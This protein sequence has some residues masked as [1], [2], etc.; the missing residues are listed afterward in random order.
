[1]EIFSFRYFFSSFSK[2]L[3]YLPVTLLI[4]IVSLVFSLA[5]GL[6]FAWCKLQKNRVV[7][8]IV[9]FYVQIIRG[10]PFI[11]L[12]FII[13]FGLPK[14]F[15]SLF[16]LDING[17]TKSIYI[18]VTL[19]M[20]GSARMSEAMRSA[21]LAVPRGQSE[22]AYSCGLSGIQT[23]FHIIFPQALYIALPNLGNLVLSNLLET[24]VG[25]SIGIIDFVGN[26]RLVNTREYG[27]HTFEIYAAV[28]LVYW[29]L[30]MLIAKLF[31]ILEAW[32]GRRQGIRTYEKAPGRKK[33]CAR[34]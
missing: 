11:V 1:M 28:A 13:Y 16:D 26:A 27:M 32:L 10:T 12:L 31:G 15:L 34:A 25:F 24:A 6:L 21:Y 18:V 17:W 4:L 23:F 9:D 30:S 29:V 22:S 7:R 19:V 5:F 3:P 33:R 2:L 20:F 14:L 8:R